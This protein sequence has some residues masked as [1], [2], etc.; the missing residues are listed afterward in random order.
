M[1][2]SAF[3]LVWNVNGAAPTYRHATGDSAVKEAERLARLNPGETFAVL[4]SVCARSVNNM[5]K[6][7]LRPTIDDIP[8]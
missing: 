2:D 6:T 4:Q 3:W 8:F 5:Q 7:D 1:S